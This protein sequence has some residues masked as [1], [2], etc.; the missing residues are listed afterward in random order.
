MDQDGKGAV[1]GPRIRDTDP[2]GITLTF[3]I[4]VM[5]ITVHKIGGTHVLAMTINKVLL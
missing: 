3:L 5:L 1:R 4:V 2:F